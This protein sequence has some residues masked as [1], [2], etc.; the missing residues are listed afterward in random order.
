MALPRAQ[1]SKR[2][3]WAKG[4][5]DL[6]HSRPIAGETAARQSAGPAVVRKAALH[7]DPAAA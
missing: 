5:Q 4:G 6:G 1:T 3:L 2:A 7:A